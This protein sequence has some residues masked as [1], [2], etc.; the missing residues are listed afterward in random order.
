MSNYH[1]DLEFDMPDKYQSYFI[2]LGMVKLIL[3][4]LSAYARA[5]TVCN[6]LKIMAYLSCHRDCRAYILKYNGFE[7]ALEYTQ[8]PQ[9]AIKFDA[10]RLLAN[11]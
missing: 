4:D 2:E 10:L 6:L 1:E 5:N 9:D 3:D 7:K 8:D 11:L